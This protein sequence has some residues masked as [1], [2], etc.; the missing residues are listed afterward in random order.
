M[1]GAVVSYNRITSLLYQ[2]ACALSILYCIPWV[3]TFS[4]ASGPTSE[5]ANISLQTVI[6]D[7]SKPAI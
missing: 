6:T 5:L 2:T 4:A 3:L 1:A 7:E